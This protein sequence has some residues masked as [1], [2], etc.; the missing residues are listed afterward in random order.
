MANI[1]FHGGEDAQI[2]LTLTHDGRLVL[3]PGI[4]KE[5]ATREVAELL[6]REYHKL[7]GYKSK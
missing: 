5:R 4:S 3:G 6:V 1:Y 7:T 2:L